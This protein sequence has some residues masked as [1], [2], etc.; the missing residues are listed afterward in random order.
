M[1]VFSASVEL[2]LMA[3]SSGFG[4]GELRQLLAQRL[5]ALVENA[6]HVIGRALV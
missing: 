4:S 6:P 2:R 5:A 3:I 1:M